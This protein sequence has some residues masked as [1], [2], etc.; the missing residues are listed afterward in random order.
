MISNQGEIDLILVFSKTFYVKLKQ[1]YIYYIDKLHNIL[2]I[3]DFF[4]KIVNFASY[5]HFVVQNNWQRCKMNNKTKFA[6]SILMLNS[7]SNIL[8]LQD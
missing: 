8:K 5:Y 4:I 2:V 7:T 1:K 3:D 6:I